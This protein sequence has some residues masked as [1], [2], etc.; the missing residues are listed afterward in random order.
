M[1]EIYARSPY[2]MTKALA[3]NNHTVYQNAPS[4]NYMMKHMHDFRIK[5]QH[6]DNTLNTLNNTP[7]ILNDH[8]STTEILTHP[9]QEIESSNRTIFCARPVFF[10]VVIETHPTLGRMGRFSVIAQPKM[11]DGS[12]CLMESGQMVV[13]HPNYTIAWYLEGFEVYEHTVVYTATSDQT[14]AIRDF[15]IRHEWSLVVNFF[16]NNMRSQ[17]HH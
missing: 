10:H 7:H 17:V 8:D 1:G 9:D 16:M 5:Q 3:E 6:R 13:M 4:L 2:D 15:E 12:A 11:P 14:Q